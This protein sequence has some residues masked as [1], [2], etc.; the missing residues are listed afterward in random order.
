[1]RV[2]LK[3]VA[4]EDVLEMWVHSN[5]GVPKGKEIEAIVKKGEAAINGT[6][7][8]IDERLNSLEI[9]GKAG[10]LEG[11]RALLKEVD[12]R[13]DQVRLKFVLMDV[14]LDDALKGGPSLFGADFGNGPP[15]I[16]GEEADLDAL[17][18]KAEDSKRATV[19]SRPCV[20][21]A[22]NQEARVATDALDADLFTLNVTP[23]VHSADEVT[24]TM[25]ATTTKEGSTSQLN[26]TV[27]LG[28]GNLVQRRR[29]NYTMR[30]LTARVGYAKQDRDQ[31]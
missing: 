8:K 23:L 31:I 7:V 9:D 10:A 4:A 15:I 29:N 26:T 1:M 25:E 13:P 27:R 2:E 18:K 24:V 21:T 5:G 3:Y 11:M 28:N 30:R 16:K 14:R 17:V 22:N 6:T 12:V 19:R 20:Y